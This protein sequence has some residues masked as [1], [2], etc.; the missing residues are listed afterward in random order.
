MRNVGALASGTPLP[1]W[2]P[3]RRG[4]ARGLVSAKE[5]G[6][7]TVVEWAGLALWLALWWLALAV[8]ASGGES[9]PAPRAVVCLSPA[10]LLRGPRQEV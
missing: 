4:S 8:G 10:G 2:N 7:V 1:L 6:R 3:A 9:E 5:R